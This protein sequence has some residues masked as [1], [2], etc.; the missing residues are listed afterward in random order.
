MRVRATEIVSVIVAVV[1]CAGAVVSAL[2]TYTNRNREL[3]IEL[4]KI[5]ISILRAD[6]KETQTN[7][8]REW[9]VQVIETYSRNAFS[10]AAKSEL[11]QN[12]LGYDVIDVYS[13]YGPRG[14]V[15]SSGF[16]DSGRIS[17]KSKERFFPPQSK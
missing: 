8:A 4:I 15:S 5:G 10:P 17:P 2:Y 13:V 3:D 11:L 6:P 14:D 9:A 16:G 7:G 12:K 1:A